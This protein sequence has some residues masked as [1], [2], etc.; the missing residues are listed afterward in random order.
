[1]ISPGV[2]NGCE[3]SG[4]KEF[5]G[6]PCRTGVTGGSGRHNHYRSAS[7][8][9]VGRKDFCCD[10]DC[11][12]MECGVVSLGVRYTNEVQRMQC[13]VASQQQ[14]KEFVCGKNGEIPYGIAKNRNTARRGGFSDNGEGS[15]FRSSDNSSE[16]RNGGFRS[17][18]RGSSI[19][20]GF[21]SNNGGGG[22]GSG[23]GDGGFRS[24][25]GEG[26]RAK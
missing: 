4:C 22:F 21:R 24:N 25:Y 26:D 10:D 16:V 17:D 1:M 14:W 6:S 7:C 9:F 8:G 20:E 15:G 2:G 23:N 11:G 13:G 12:Y 19:G 18:G 5:A 3:W